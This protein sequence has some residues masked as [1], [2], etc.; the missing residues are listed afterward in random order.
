MKIPT[1]NK[2]WNRK[3]ENLEK[4]ENWKKK[5]KVGSRKFFRK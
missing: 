1:K 3:Y 2:N 5:M 4:N